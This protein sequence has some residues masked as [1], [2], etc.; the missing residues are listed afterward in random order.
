MLQMFP[1]SRYILR[2]LKQHDFLENKYFSLNFRSRD[3]K[4][5][6]M[7][8]NDRN[9]ANKN[10]NTAKNNN[11]PVLEKPQNPT[12]MFTTQS[13][14]KYPAKYK[15]ENEMNGTMKSNFMDETKEDKLLR[16][17]FNS[18]LN[19]SIV[20]DTSKPKN[21]EPSEREKDLLNHL[22]LSSIVIESDPNDSNRY[23]KKDDPGDWYRVI[24]KGKKP[25]DPNTKEKK[26]KQS[27]KKKSKSSESEDN[28]GERRH[29][30]KKHRDN[31][32][33]SQSDVGLET[34]IKRR[35]RNRHSSSDSFDNTLNLDDTKLKATSSSQSRQ[36]RI[37]ESKPA[38]KSSSV[39]NDRPVTKQPQQVFSAPVAEH[40]H[41]P[42]KA[43]VIVSKPS[44][45][46]VP[47]ENTAK[48]SVMQINS[49][50]GNQQSDNQTQRKV[51]ISSSSSE[52]FSHTNPQRNTPLRSSQTR[53]N[54]F[55]SSGK[56]LNST[57]EN[58]GNT[59]AEVKRPDIV[60]PLN[61]TQTGNKASR[62][63][64]DFEELLLSEC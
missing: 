62:L 33:R 17:Q 7:I 15:T 8:P 20:S 48:G 43:R 4:R 10:G 13:V 61:L 11:K 47:K 12:D 24:M 42:V 58:E 26:E 36:P 57:K 29:R 60:P 21:Y 9:K 2:F 37:V 59:N 55:G 19:A 63:D 46:I 39:H 44:S 28:S 3:A 64:D 32:Q 35:S 5:K 27:R 53:N 38:N 16:E 18:T 23:F 25:R 41:E 22:E 6:T 50:T 52:S 54:L 49:K 56:K 45:D 14:G 40:K 31:K 30:R 1:E 34:S 51:S